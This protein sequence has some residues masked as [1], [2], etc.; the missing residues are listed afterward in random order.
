[1]KI[2]QSN[3]ISY[4]IYDQEEA[5]QK[6]IIT[7]EKIK[8]KKHILYTYRLDADTLIQIREGKNAERIINKLR[9]KQPK[10]STTEQ[11]AQAYYI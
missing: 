2:K 6:A 11:L 5:I 1:M 8:R 3:R 4:K 7:L 9:N 10:I